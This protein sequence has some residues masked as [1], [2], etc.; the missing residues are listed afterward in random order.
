MEYPTIQTKDA[1]YQC[2]HKQHLTKTLHNHDDEV[3]FVCEVSNYKVN[4]C[5]DCKEHNAFKYR[6]VY[7][8]IA[9]PCYD[10]YSILFK[11]RWPLW[12]GSMLFRE[13]VF[14]N[15]KD[16]DGDGYRTT[17]FLVEYDINHHEYTPV[18]LYKGDRFVPFCGYTV[19][20]MQFLL[21]HDREA[22][23]AEKDLRDATVDD[24]KKCLTVADGPVIS[25]G[26]KGESDSDELYTRISL[27]PDGEWGL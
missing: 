15:L 9:N 8:A 26:M 17:K 23:Q 25:P 20:Y 2:G 3:D 18:G 7:A 24:W 21:R 16:E 13:R 1:Y 12:N 11:R 10:L 22:V 5:P 4:L 14:N 27:R 19:E 6:E